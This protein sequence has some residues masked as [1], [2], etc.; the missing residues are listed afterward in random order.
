M[1]VTGPF[2]A[3]LESR[4]PAER[5]AVTYVSSDFFSVLRTRPLLGRDFRAEDDRQG[6]HPVAILSHRVW[7]T[8]LG[9]DPA[10]LGSSISLDRRPY[11]VIG[12]L[13]PSSVSIALRTCLFRSATQ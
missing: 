12:V 2:E 4:A 1:A 13:G 11:T 8:Y 5:L 7:Q 9:S 3:T 10:I 6:A